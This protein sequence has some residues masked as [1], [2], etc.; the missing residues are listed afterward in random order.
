L[1]DSDLTIGGI[2][3]KKRDGGELTTDEIGFFVRGV[4]SGAIPDYQA[5]AWLMAV[6]LRGMSRRETGDLTLAMRDSGERLDLCSLSPHP[7]LDKHSTGGVGDKT[8]L[9]VAPILAAAGIP[10]LKMSGRGLGFSGGTVDELE[11]IPAFR[12]ELSVNEAMDQVRLI[13]LALIGQSADL[14]PADKVLYA[15]RDVTATIES[16]PL[17]ASSIMSKK[18]AAGGDKILLDVKAGRGAFMNTRDQAAELARLLISIGNEAGVPTTALLSSMDE[19]LG[20]AVG[21]AVEVEE[22]VQLLLAPANAEPTF[23]AFCSELAAH[24]LIAADKAQTRE[25]ALE[26]VNELLTSGKAARKFGQVV[27]AQGGPDGCEAILASL[28][29]APIQR[30]V[31][32]RAS[33]LIVSIDAEA[34]GRLAMMMGAGRQ[35][36]K[37]E[38]DHAVGIVFEG[39][40]G[41]TVR[42][43]DTLATLHIRYSDEDRAAAFEAELQEACCISNDAAAQPERFWTEYLQ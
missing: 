31:T 26:R 25:R 2:L 15:L 3:A 1:P 40:S 5:A 27:K 35:S 20:R 11:S 42:G 9:V 8:T 29:R 30:V 4:T 37:D 36:K 16:L 18:L 19:P 13:H 12:S 7:I 23:L 6:F 28:P 41:E 34:V 43:G 22:A 32:A 24:G 10:M 17:I 39:K 14:A 33:G 21:N 38:I